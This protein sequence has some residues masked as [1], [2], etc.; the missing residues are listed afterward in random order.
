MRSHRNIKNQQARV[1][2]WKQREEG[3]TVVAKEEDLGLEVAGLE[4]IHNH[5]FKQD[6]LKVHG[7]F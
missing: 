1:G 3:M 6:Q 5:I 4:V 7:T 2:Y